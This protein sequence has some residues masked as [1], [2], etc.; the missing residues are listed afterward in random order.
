MKSFSDA[1]DTLVGNMEKVGA[2]GKRIKIIVDEN[3]VV[4]D[5]HTSPPV[6]TVNHD[7]VDLTI[8]ASLKDFM[9][10]V[11]KQLN[12]TVAFMSGKIKVEGDVKSALPLLKLF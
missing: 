2:F 11:G 1:I 12:P 3:E 6:L 7:N 9:K 5:G 4:I 10:L 8:R